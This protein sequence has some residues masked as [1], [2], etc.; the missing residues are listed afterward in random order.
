MNAVA[1]I[2]KLT[3]EAVGRYGSFGGDRRIGKK[4]R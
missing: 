4:P 2:D 3:L 1:E